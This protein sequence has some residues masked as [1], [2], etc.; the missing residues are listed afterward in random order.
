MRHLR[1]VALLLAFI[2]LPCS[3]FAADEVLSKAKQ[4]LESGNAQEAYTLLVPLQSERAGDPDYDYLLGSSALELGKNTEAVFALER[5]LAIQ[6]NSAPARAQIARAYYNLKEMDT[7]KREFEN[8]RK[9]DVP[10]EVSATIERFLD[11]ITRVQESERTVIRGFVEV[12]LGY[13]TNVNSATAD[14]QVAVPSFG[15]L[16]FTLAPSATKQGDEFI[17]FGGGVGFVHP[18]SKRFSMFG[19]LAYQ[20][21][22]NTSEDDFSTYSYD[23]NLGLSYRWDRDTLTLAGQYNSFW[24]DNPQ[25]YSDAY[26]NASGATAQWQH[27]FDARNQVSVFLQYSELIYPGQEIRDANRY[28]G[29]AGYAHAFGRGAVI[30]Y[31]GVYGG[32]EKQKADSVPEFGNDIYGV[33]LG[34]QWNIN[35]KYALFGNAS[36]EQRKY[37]GTDPFFLTDRKDDQYGAS[38]GLI[39]VPK[40]NVRI[41]PQVSWTDNQSNIAIYEFNRVIYQ[42]TLR[43]DM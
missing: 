11:A 33:R 30:T 28:I 15:G 9:Q 14:N 7:A 31:A 22:T 25:L 17:T 20:N 1:Q 4:L 34:A 42:V 36:A 41:T 12:G 8:V 35:E 43:Q 16:I 13:D 37:K 2:A 29:G 3:V 40:K 18:F 32:T 6:P 19:G 27:D 38:A 26:R 10:V 5:V 23:I 21:K 39:F 24:V